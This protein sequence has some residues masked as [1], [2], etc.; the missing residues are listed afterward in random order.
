MSQLYFLPTHL[1]FIYPFF[2]FYLVQYEL[3]A[4]PRKMQKHYVKKEFDLIWFTC[5]YLLTLLLASGSRKQL[6][7]DVEC[8]F[9]A[10]LADGSRL[11]QQVRL[12]VCTGDV[13]RVVK[14]DTD[15]FTLKVN[16]SYVKSCLLDMV[17]IHFFSFLITKIKL[18]FPSLER[19]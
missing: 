14:V 5:Y 10:G 4:L 18:H 11:L 12:N 16:Q 6:V 2:F 1:L 9:I 13:S 7:E 15:E 3:Y 8:A 17:A 19:K